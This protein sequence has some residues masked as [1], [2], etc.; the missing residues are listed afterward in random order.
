MPTTPSRFTSGVATALPTETLAWFIEPDLT[1]VVKFWDDFIDYDSSQWVVTTTEAGTGTASEAVQDEVGGVLKL[2]NDD[3]DNDNDFLQWDG[4][5][6]SGGTEIFKLTGNERAWFKARFKLSDATQSDAVIGLQIIDT[7][8]L[9]VTDGVFFQKDDGDTNLD[10][11]VE[12][13][14]TATTE[15]AVTSLS[16]DTYVTVGFY[17]DKS[18][19][20]VYV[21]DSKVATVDDANIPNDTELTV[22]FGVQNGA[23]A[24]KSMSVD[25]IF[26]AQDRP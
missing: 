16:N 11:H 8:P 13:D 15:T 23:A 3:A 9:D 22:S 24:A 25:Y 18:N 5:S 2:T 7:S 1:K 6:S 12:K 10:F 26:A 19:F 14:N 21:N 20:Q 4:V 17:Y